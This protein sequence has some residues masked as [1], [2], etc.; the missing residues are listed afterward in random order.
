MQVLLNIIFYE[1]I[2]M[3]GNSLF[4]VKHKKLVTWRRVF[5]CLMKTGLVLVIQNIT[6]IVYEF[7]KTFTGPNLLKINRFTFERRKKLICVGVYCKINGTYMSRK[8]PVSC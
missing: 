1:N 6:L 8:G 2:L 3:M 4:Q 5:P 7:D